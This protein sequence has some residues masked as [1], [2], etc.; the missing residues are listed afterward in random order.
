MARKRANKTVKPIGVIEVAPNKPKINVTSFSRRDA[1]IIQEM[2]N[3][4]ATYGGLLKQQ[5]QYDAMIFALKLRKEQILKGEIPLPVVIRITDEISYPES[6]K[7]KVLEY[8]DAKIKDIQLARDGVQG[9]LDYRRDA[10]VEAMIKVKN[11]LTDKTKN[12]E[13]KKIAMVNNS[14]KSNKEEEKKVLEK[15]F[16]EMIK[17]GEK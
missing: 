14:S 4:N 15:E 12:N 7:N 11:I 10:F 3:L 16:D 9:L 13:T 17:K 1:E 5:Q 6:N 8:M 2:W